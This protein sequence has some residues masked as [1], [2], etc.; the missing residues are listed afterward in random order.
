MKY[1][2]E[3][4]EKNISRIR[5][6]EKI[7]EDPVSLVPDCIDD[8]M[9]CPLSG[10]RK[11]LSGISGPDDLEKLRKSRDEFLRGIGE[12]ARAIKDEDISFSGLLKTP[13]GTATFYKK[14]DTDQYVLAGIQNSRND[15]FR[16]LAFSKDVISGR[17]VLYS[18]G[19][20]FKG[21]CRRSPPDMEFISIV[22]EEEEIDHHTDT[23]GQISTGQGEESFT[24]NIYG[25]PVVRIYSG[26]K[27]STIS[28]ISKH[29]L[30]Q[31][32]SKIYSYSFENLNS[33][34]SRTETG[35]FQRYISGEI[36]DSEFISEVMKERI[37]MAK[38]S[39]KYIIGK[40]V[41]TDLGK[42]MENIPLDENE[43]SALKSLWNPDV[44]IY[45]E[46]PTRRKFLEAV[47]DSVGNAMLKSLFP[48]LDDD[49]IDSLKGNPSEV[50]EKA[51][52]IEEIEAISGELDLKPWSPSSKYLASLVVAGRHGGR[53]EI[54]EVMGMSKVSDP[55][56]MAINHAF[57]IVT[58]TGKSESW[59][60]SDNA[61]LK[62]ELLIPYVRK[63]L[64]GSPDEVR[65]TY[66]EMEKFLR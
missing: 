63:M 20:Y 37:R 46:S 65:T 60:A 1:K 7:L 3:S 40:Q 32:P 39:G 31:D 45:I 11:K 62:G 44:G 9:F 57:V 47:W 18:A 30:C 64:E 58:E 36:N 27:I 25:Q 49:Q 6:I 50:I 4:K 38:N 54:L 15:I 16:M 51:K 66:R 42:F 12:T 56:S 28:R 26:S 14:G 53:D 13:H 23:S 55:D 41:F 43:K 59:K 24:L 2:R 48:G 52:K 10:Y 61:K 35:I 29:I 33:F 22:L 19:D 8:G 21:S 34:S 5:E 17:L